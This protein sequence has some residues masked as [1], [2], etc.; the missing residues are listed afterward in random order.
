MDEGNALVLP[1]SSFLDGKGAKS[2]FGV[3]EQTSE[4]AMKAGYP[5]LCGPVF[6]NSQ[7]DHVVDQGPGHAIAAGFGSD[8]DI[9]DN[10]VTVRLPAKKVGKTDGLA[11]RYG[12]G[13][14]GP[15]DDSLG[16]LAHGQGETCPGMEEK[17]FLAALGPGGDED[18]VLVL[19][20][21][22]T[23]RLTHLLAIVSTFHLSSPLG[24]L[25]VIWCGFDIF[26][27]H[28]HTK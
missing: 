14:I 24:G 23:Q 22:K 13:R 4:I 25:L 21:P 19:N 9:A 10:A 16:Q 12:H 1:I 20:G 8:D 11:I 15:L 3:E 18:Q 27:D 5:D 2:Q 28:I 6:A 17:Q 26:G 7:N